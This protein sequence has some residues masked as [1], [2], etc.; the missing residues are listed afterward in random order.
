MFSSPALAPAKLA[1]LYRGSKMTYGNEASGIARTYINHL[2]RR[3]HLLPSKGAALEIGC[4]NG[5]FLRELT[6]FG[7]DEVFGVEPS[8]DA[9]AQAGDLTSRIYHGFFENAF[10]KPGS[11]DLICCFQTLDHVINPLAVL[12]KCWE[13]LRPD[14]MLYVIVH[15]E[16]ALQARLFG[17]KSPIYDVEHIYLFN[18]STLARACEKAGLQTESVFSVR[19]TYPLEYWLRMSPI[20]GKKFFQRTSEILHVSRLPVT[21]PAGNLGIFARK[22]C[23]PKN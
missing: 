5:F 16:R 17:E 6:K 23:D 1:E 21:I 18:R 10:F 8:E 2:R 20:P 9:I 22:P 19:N 12:T 15:N 3:E 11:L 4:G 13:L 14:G 7:F